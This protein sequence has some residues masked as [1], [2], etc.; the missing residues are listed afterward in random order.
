MTTGC[1]ERSITSRVTWSVAWARSISIPSRF[2][3]RTTSIPNGVSPP[4]TTGSVWMSPTSFT[5]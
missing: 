1:V 2:I 5:R 3:S 4:W